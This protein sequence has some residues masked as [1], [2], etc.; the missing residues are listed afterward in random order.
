MVKAATGLGDDGLDDRFATPP[1]VKPV[2]RLRIF[3]RIRALGTSPDATQGYRTTQSVYEMANSDSPKLLAPARRVFE[4]EIWEFLRQPD[5]PI[6]DYTRVIEA[7]CERR[8]WY[9]ARREELRIGQT[10]LG[11]DEPAF[12]QG[13]SPAY[14]AMLQH[15]VEAQ[16][17]I[18]ALTLLVALFRE[19]YGSFQL[20]QA[21]AIRSALR[22]AAFSYAKACDV[23]DDISVLLNR[24][25]WDRIIQNQIVNDDVLDESDGNADT[26]QSSDATPGQKMQ[27]FVKRYVS[28]QLHDWD[29]APGVVA[30]VPRTD[31]IDWLLENRTGLRAGAEM[32]AQ[33]ERAFHA[34]DDVERASPREA[35]RMLRDEIL[36]MAEPP[37][38]EGTAALPV[39]GSVVMPS[40][41]E[42]FRER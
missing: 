38:R 15:L 32:V 11:L 9:R 19:A 17:D 34:H 28:G 24:L 40:L 29:A 12:Q 16:P 27:R 30:I 4:S 31:R 3:F 14:H 39:S 13:M 8:G 26:G 6:A 41:E 42:M 10:F 22:S 21:M 20:D 37:Q 18:E 33:A 25:I 1:N 7:I 23:P 35:A 2:A 36:S 5:R